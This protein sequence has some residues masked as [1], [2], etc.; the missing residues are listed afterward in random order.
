MYSTNDMT[1]ESNIETIRAMRRQEDHYRVSDYLSDLPEPAA[2]STVDAPVDASCRFLMAK[3]FG[4]IAGFCHYKTETV[5]IAMNCLDRFV[6]TPE[7][8]EILFDRN[9]YQLAAMTALYSSVK[10]HEQ[11]AMDPALVSTLSRGVHSPEA[12]EAMERKML[13]AV[14]WRV[15][16]PSAMSFARLMI[17]LIPDQYL[18]SHQKEA[19]LD[20]TKLQIDM[21]INEYDFCT[22]YASSV[23][24]A[25]VLNAIE[26]ITDDGMFYANVETTMGEVVNADDTSVQDLRFAIYELMTG[27]DDDVAQRISK[28]SAK[29]GVGSSFTMDGNV[30]K[31]NSVHSSPRTVAAA[32]ISTR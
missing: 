24:F 25:C 26:S 19:L 28:T 27:T 11:E 2:C 15:N 4:E 14:Q 1:T 22:H 9:L 16:Q 31:R 13:M 10:I 20:I 7:G 5:A 21:T 3:W 23:A 30:S 17:G 29:R 8:R 18:D 6:S 32:S 12:V